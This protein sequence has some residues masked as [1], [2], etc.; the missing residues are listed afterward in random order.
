[1]A[2][3]GVA[4][5]TLAVGEFHD[6]DR[7]EF[8]QELVHFFL[9]VA[10]SFSYDQIGKI[11]EGALICEGKAVAGFDKGA[12]IAGEIPLCILDGFIR[13][14]AQTHHAGPH[15]HGDLLG[16]VGAEHTDHWDTVIFQLFYMEKR[17]FP[18]VGKFSEDFW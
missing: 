18:L 12:E 3:H 8:S 10:G 4:I 15:C 11:E 5:G 6:V 2:V 7:L 1:M 16:E 9:A 17:S 14:G 13:G